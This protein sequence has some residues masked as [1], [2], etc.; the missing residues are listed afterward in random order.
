MASAQS[1][2][3]VYGGLY[4]AAPPPRRPGLDL[5]IDYFHHPGTSCACDTKFYYDSTNIHD[6]MVCQ[7][8]FGVPPLSAT[9]G[10]RIS[11]IAL[12]FP[13]W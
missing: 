3:S 1:A 9:T 2:N 8:G 10:L 7:S 13:M 12:E 4:C 6:L 11:I 5:G